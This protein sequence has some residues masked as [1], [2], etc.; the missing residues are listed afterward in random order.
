MIPRR[1]RYGEN[2]PISFYCRRRQEK[3]RKCTER[4][5]WATEALWRAD[6]AELI[7]TKIDI[8]L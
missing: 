4:N 1:L 6:S 5:K 7:F 8:L 2:L 3:L